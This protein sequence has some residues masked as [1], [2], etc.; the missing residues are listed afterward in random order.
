MEHQKYT[1][2]GRHPDPVLRLMRLHVR[3]QELETVFPHIQ[4]HPARVLLRLG[5]RRGPH[6]HLAGLDVPI[7]ELVPQEV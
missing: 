6:A 5:A 1:L 4:Q 3:V 7:G 2:K